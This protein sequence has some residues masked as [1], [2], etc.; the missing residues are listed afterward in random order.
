MYKVSFMRK[1]TLKVVFSCQSPCLL[2]HCKDCWNL[3]KQ[4]LPYR[5]RKPGKFLL[6]F[7]SQWR[8]GLTTNDEKLLKQ[9]FHK[10]WAVFLR[11]KKC[12]KLQK[13]LGCSEDS[14]SETC[15]LC[16][17]RNI[18]CRII[19]GNTSHKVGFSQQ[20]QTKLFPILRCVATPVEENTGKFLQNVQFVERKFPNWKE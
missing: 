16:E 7:K 13:V 5:K 10:S 20:I 1:H 12:E 15:F 17:S 9:K 4:W 3:R 11:K 18:D 8:R 14:V 2:T 6:I 19:H